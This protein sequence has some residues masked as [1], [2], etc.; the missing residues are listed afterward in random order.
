MT[1]EKVTIGLEIHA[2]LATRAKMFCECPIPAK[3]APHNSVVCETCTGQPGAKPMAVSERVLEDAV[4]LALALE[5]KVAV[6]GLVVQRKHY[7]YPDLPSGYQRTSLPLATGG[8]LEGVRIREVHIEEDPGNYEL[9]TGKVDYNR[10]G[11]PLAEIVTDPDITSPAHARRFLE[12]LQAVFNYLGAVRNEPGSMRADANISLP[13]GNRVEVKNINS[14]RGVEKALLYEVARQGAML[15]QGLS[16]AHETRHYDEEAELTMPL[17]KKELA[18]DY[19]FMPDPDL[20]N[21]SLPAGLL[22]R[23]KAGMPELPTQKRKRFMQQYGISE[24]EAFVLTLELDF[25]NAYEEIAKLSKDPVLAARFLRGVVRKQLHYRSLEYKGS[26]LGPKLLAELVLLVKEGRATEK[27]AEQA[28]IA[29]LDKGAA[30]SEFVQKEGLGGV[31]RGDELGNAV[32]EAMAANK[33]AVES[34][35]AGNEKAMQFIAGE[36]MKRTKKRADPKEIQELLRRALKA[37]G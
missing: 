22:E 24:I 13:G 35:R 19:R 12:S 15:K 7:F 4:A 21:L 10:S 17:R 25:A 34:F 9:K 2:P 20:P 27:V 8:V 11:T 30:P 32:R 33:E 37:Q 26:K 16:V 18:A 29:F 6:G 28:L 31:L 36:V 23:V 14:F 5:C 3:D 1:E